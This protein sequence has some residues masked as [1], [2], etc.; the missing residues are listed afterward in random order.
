MNND[1]EVTGAL[2]YWNT[3]FQMW[4]VCAS[5]H[6]DAVNDS[7]AHVITGAGVCNNQWLY[8]QATTTHGGNLWGTW[9]DDNHFPGSTGIEWAYV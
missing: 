4:G 1:Q 9:Y 2:M 8:V 7:W 5:T 3:V 6:H